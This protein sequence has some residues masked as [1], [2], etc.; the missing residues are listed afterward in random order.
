MGVQNWLG[1]LFMGIG[2]IAFFYAR[3]VRTKAEDSQLWPIPSL[4]GLQKPRIV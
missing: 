4:F 3:Q 1:L 2:A